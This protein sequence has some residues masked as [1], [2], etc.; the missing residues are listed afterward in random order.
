MLRNSRRSSHASRRL[1][2]LL[3]VQLS[4]FGANSIAQTAPSDS[5]PSLPPALERRN[6]PD[7]GKLPPSISAEPIENGA[8]RVTF[9]HRPEQPAATIFLAGSFNGW[10][11]Q[12]TPMTGPNGDGQWM[13]SVT[14]GG[15]DYQYKFVI[16]GNRW[17]HDNQNPEQV[18]D[19]H[20]GHNSVLR[21][22]A[23]ANVRE[24]AARVADGEI[25]VNGLTHDPRLPQYFQA[26]AP[27]KALF[28]YR[29][30]AHD[31][32]SVEVALHDGPRHAMV[33]HTETPVFSYWEAIVTLPAHAGPTRTIEYTFVIRDGQKTGRDP[34]DY[35][36]TVGADTIFS[37]PEWA[38]HAIWY[39]IMVD[40]F[41]NADPA[42][43]PTK[44]VPWTQE[45]FS[46]AAFEGQSGSSFYKYDV[47][48][49]LYGGDFQG[50]RDRLTYLRE[51]G[52][53]ALY[54]N[55]VFKAP[56]HHKYDADSYLHIDDHFGVKGDYDRVAG[57]EDMNDPATWQ[58]TESDKVFLDFLKAA[59]S[60]GFR[61]ILDGVFNH[62]GVGH[63]AFQDVKQN[64]QNSRYAD[65]FDVTSW[66]PFKYNGWAG[67]DTLPVFRK[68][69]TD[70]ASQAVKQ[71][72]FNV[73]RRW[74][75]PNGDGDPSDGIDGWR[76]D[77]P[78]EVPAP[79]WVEWRALVKSINPNAYI[80]GEIWDRADQWLDGRHFDAVMNYQFADAAISWIGHKKR[81]TRVSQI[82]R[83]LAELRL[84]YPAA[85]TY[86]MQNLTNSHDTDRLVSMIHNPD[87]GYDQQNRIQDNGPN[88]DNSKP[89]P[90][91]YQRAR[92]VV[93]LQ[94]TYVGAPMI[95]YGD[96]VGM[97]GADDP[98][99]RKPMLW[100]DLQPYEKPQENFVMREHLDFYK[101]AIALRN[102]NSALRDGYFHT[103][104]ANDDADVWVFERFNDEQHV[105]VALNASDAERTVDVPLSK[106]HATDWNVV[107]GGDGAKKSAAGRLSL[108]VPPVSGVVLRAQK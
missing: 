75:D 106:H 10:N 26:L 72:I 86:V 18:P 25:E 40:R 53:N 35:R 91:A 95:Y 76:L 62:V 101:A 68:T 7:P 74:M 66:D 28:R 5:S 13:G 56:S 54:F 88:Y 30:M 44:T 17:V 46:P 93:L 90:A 36:A 81:K 23:L 22:G 48:F 33:L 84:A 9:R 79:F 34:Q 99:C 83:R 63:P 102:Q 104:L 12:S 8:W 14:L 78:N 80:T 52:V 38:R 15:G 89:G 70:L 59:K 64:R 55:P 71:H 6:P 65:W 82:D 29:T 61:V 51:L 42:N 108:K 67:V 24:S 41:R 107:F 50:V 105:I 27:D 69:P 73:T 45:W 2:A 92:L 4:F 32:E 77:V 97:W 1:L 31:V 19:G 98:T 49:R 37:T 94:M 43:D 103:L 87:R 100:E 58:W 60:M 21:I 3:T 57:S 47:F 85:A 39:Q 16:D 20:Q 96:E 11:P